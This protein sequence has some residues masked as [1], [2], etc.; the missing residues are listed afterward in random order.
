MELDD[1]SENFMFPKKFS[2]LLY[3]I[4]C[5]RNLFNGDSST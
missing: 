2:V 1:A 5:G 4:C 3:V